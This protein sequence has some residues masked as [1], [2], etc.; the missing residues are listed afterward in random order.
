[1][2]TFSLGK[3]RL[4]NLLFFLY[5]IVYATSPLIYTFPEQK[6]LKRSRESSPAA[7]VVKV[8]AFPVGTCHRKL[9]SRTR[10]NRHRQY[11]YNQKKRALRRKTR[12][13]DI[14]VRYDINPRDRYAPP[15]DQRRTAGTWRHS[16]RRLTESPAFSS[17]D[18]TSTSQTISHLAGTLFLSTSGLVV[19]VASQSLQATARGIRDRCLYHKIY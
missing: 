13:R 15:P 14:A 3:K 17:W 7:P 16:T 18:N 1:M 12:R 2:I 4:F 5:Y 8:S 9:F 10:Q 6:N 11:R 19:R